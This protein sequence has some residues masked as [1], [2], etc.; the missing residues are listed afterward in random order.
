MQP[1]QDVT[2][3]KVKNQQSVCHSQ[4]CSCLYELYSVCTQVRA[5]SFYCSLPAKKWQLF[6]ELSIIYCPSFTLA[7]QI[8]GGNYILISHLTSLVSFKNSTRVLEWAHGTVGK[9]GNKITVTT[10]LSSI[11][12]SAELRPISI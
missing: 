7:S 4:I 8:H 9:L 11:Y 1:V 6:L 10:S 2:Q 5:I 3:P 12:Y